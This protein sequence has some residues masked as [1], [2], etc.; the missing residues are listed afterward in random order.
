MGIFLHGQY[1]TIVVFLQA[2]FAEC[3]GLSNEESMRAQ[4]SR[5]LFWQ[6]GPKT[7]DNSNT[8]KFVNIQTQRVE[9][10]M[11]HQRFTLQQTAPSLPPMPSAGSFV[12]LPATSAA[13]PT[14]QTSIYELARAAALQQTRDRVFRRFV[15]RALFSCLN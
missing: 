9:K 15:D 14:D 7:C 1:E 4:R 5:R 11:I 12:A 8:I 10:I 13:S 2:D 6:R 3:A